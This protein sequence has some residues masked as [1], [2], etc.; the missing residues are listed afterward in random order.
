M[1]QRQTVMTLRVSSVILINKILNTVQI[2]YDLH[3]LLNFI[4]L[5][6]LVFKMSRILSK[7]FFMGFKLNNASC[8][9]NCLA[10]K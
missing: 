5:S 2:K 3:E 10:N 1:L 7:R 6:L 8:F 9:A 4:K